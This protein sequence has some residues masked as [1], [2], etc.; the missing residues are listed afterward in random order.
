MEDTSKMEKLGDSNYQTW[1][2]Q[3]KMS[4]MTKGLWTAVSG[5]PD[6]EDATVRTQQQQQDSKAWAFI[7]LGVEKHHL[8]VVSNTT[9]AKEAWEALKSLFAASSGAR[10]MALLQEISSISK[11]PDESISRY[12]ARVRA[13]GD[14][15]E[16]VGSK[17]PEEQ[18]AL[19]LLK[20]LPSQYA[21]VV[22]MLKGRAEEPTIASMQAQL[23]LP[24]AEFSVGSG[25]AGIGGNLAPALFFWW[26]P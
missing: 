9:T 1:S 17:M 18:L 21:M 2:T 4:L 15:L 10:K 16:A 14:Q 7:G 19:F 26:P 24:E 13:V 11:Q 6:T 12:S 25:S 22:T 23:L 3:M 5:F 20:G 8:G